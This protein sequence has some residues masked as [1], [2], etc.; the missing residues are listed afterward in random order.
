[1]RTE[2]TKFQCWLNSLEKIL[3]FSPVKD[4]VL[5]DFNDHETF[6]GFVFN[7]VDIEHYRV[8]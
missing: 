8:Q 5:H 7:K 6:M 1:M 3:S 4:Y 2:D